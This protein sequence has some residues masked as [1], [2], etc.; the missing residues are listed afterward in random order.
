MQVRSLL[1]GDLNKYFYKFN[2]Y[3]NLYKQL[4]IPKLSMSGTL[5][6][7]IFMDINHVLGIK[8]F[9]SLIPE[10]VHEPPY[11]LFSDYRAEFF[12]KFGLLINRVQGWLV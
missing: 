2:S 12:I 1:L 8:L 10:I 11:H 6:E 5:V 9:S 3:G 4:N 7:S